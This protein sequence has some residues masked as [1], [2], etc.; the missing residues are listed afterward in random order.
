M[1]RI[2]ASIFF[3]LLVS[4]AAY[5]NETEQAI[6]QQFEKYMEGIHKK[7]IDLAMEIFGKDV[8]GEFQDKP[9][10]NFQDIRKDILKSFDESESLEYQIK[11]IIPSHDLAVVRVDWIVRSLDKN[12]GKVITVEKERGMDVFKRYN[13][14]WKIYRYLAY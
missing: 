3:L 1:K 8:T 6:R 13:N 14:E 7:D 12:T 4:N 11:E 5:P 9:P 10:R 2:I